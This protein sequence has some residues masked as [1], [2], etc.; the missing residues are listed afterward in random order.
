MSAVP[1]VSFA[2]TYTQFLDELTA[3]FPEYAVPL[4]AAKTLPNARSV[5]LS[6]WKTHTKMI[7]QQKADIFTGAG[8]D[9]VPGVKMTES[10]WNELSANSQAAIWKYLTTLLL[11][12]VSEETKNE[13]IWDM[14]GFEHDMEEMMRRMKSGEEGSGMKDIFEKLTSMMDMSGAFGQFAKAFSGMAGGLGGLGEDDVSGLSL[15]H[16]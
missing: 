5:F 2:N 3:T 16:I 11:I 6:V 7:S 14:S 1:S 10:L 4:S 9:L 12:G 8:L 15:I 13:G